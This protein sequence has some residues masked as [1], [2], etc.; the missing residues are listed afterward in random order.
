MVRASIYAWTRAWV[1]TL[2]GHLFPVLCCRPKLVL[3]GASLGSMDMKKSLEGAFIGLGVHWGWSRLHPSE[4]ALL[5]CKNKCV[6]AWGAVF[7]HI[8]NTVL[9][10]PPTGPQKEV[11]SYCSGDIH[12][13]VAARRTSPGG[14][15]WAIC[16]SWHKKKEKPT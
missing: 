11:Q 4:Q 10:F 14:Q 7:T 1:E 9:S 12:S 3:D 13:R 5:V 8:P 6:E 2:W 15:C 16:K